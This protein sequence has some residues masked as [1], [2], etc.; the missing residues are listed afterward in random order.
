MCGARM[1][2]R[3]GVSATCGSRI[4]SK[5]TSG[6]EPSGE[7]ASTTHDPIHMRFSPNAPVSTATMVSGK[8]GHRSGARNAASTALSTWHGGGGTSIGEHL[9]RGASR[10]LEGRGGERPRVIMLDTESSGTVRSICFSL[11]YT[12]W[13]A[14]V[15]SGEQDQPFRCN[16]RRNTLGMPSTISFGK[17][18]RCAH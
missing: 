16:K 2:W 4:G 9:L 15:M 12:R 6:L 14:P 7:S 18:L 13:Y 8:K 17:R 1:V 11:F 5:H 10:G 3:S